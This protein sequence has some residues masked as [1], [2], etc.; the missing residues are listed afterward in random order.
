MDKAYK[1]MCDW[2]VF[3]DNYMEYVDVNSYEPTGKY[4]IYDG[5]K[6][7]LEFKA[8][9]RIKHMLFKDTFEE[10]IKWVK[11]SSI[12]FLPNYKEYD[13]HAD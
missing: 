9:V 13:C 2:Q 12:L 8:Q 10:R 6:M 1:I 7:V 5:G 11:E 4:R 3:S